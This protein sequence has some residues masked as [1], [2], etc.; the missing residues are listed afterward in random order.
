MLMNLCFDVYIDVCVWGYMFGFLIVLDKV[1]RICFFIIYRI[2]F[3]LFFKIVFFLLKFINFFFL[4]FIKKYIIRNEV[5][6]LMGF[7]YVLKFNC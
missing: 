5:F 3:C 1:E 6:Y 7:F 2:G 4:K